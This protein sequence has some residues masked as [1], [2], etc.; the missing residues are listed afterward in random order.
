MSAENECVKLKV[1]KSLNKLSNNLLNNE[2]T[3]PMTDKTASTKVECHSPT[4]LSQTTTNKNEHDQEEDDK[5][6]L[7]GCCVCGDDT[8]YSN[9][10]LVYC[11]GVDCKVAVHQCC[12]GILNVPDDS[13]YCG[14]CKHK[15]ELASN[16]LKSK[17]WHGGRH[18]HDQ[19]KKLTCELC[20]CR[21]GALKRTQCNKWAH[22]V[23]ALYIPE[24]SFGNVK[25]MEPI[26]LKDIKCQRFD[27]KCSLCLNTDNSCSQGVYVNCGYKDGCQEW[28]HVTCAQRKGLLCEESNS[29]Y[30]NN[31]NYSIYCSEHLNLIL[32]QSTSC[33]KKL[34]PFNSSLCP[35]S[36]PLN[37]NNLAKSVSNL[38]HSVN[39][40]LISNTIVDDL[41]AFIEAREKEKLKEKLKLNAKKSSRGESHMNKSRPSLVKNSKQKQEPIIDLSEKKKKRFSFNN[42]S[43][44]PSQRSTSKQC[45]VNKAKLD[46]NGTDELDKTK[47][48]QSESKL[49]E[50]NF[51]EVKIFTGTNIAKLED[52]KF[53]VL[54]EQTDNE[55]NDECNSIKSFRS[56]STANSCTSKRKSMSSNVVENE[57]KKAKTPKP[58]NDD[59]N[60]LLAN[61][62]PTLT[63]NLEDAKLAC[64]SG[65]VT[66]ST[67]SCASST[68]SNFSKSPESVDIRPKCKNPLTNHTQTQCIDVFG[69]F[70]NKQMEPNCERDLCEPTNEPDNSLEE[71]LTKQWDLGAD[72]CRNLSKKFDC[73]DLLD[74]LY[75]CK[76]DNLEMEK[77]LKL[78][79]QNN[80]E[81]EQ[82][83][84]KLSRSFNQADEAASFRKLIQP[85]NQHQH[86]NQHEHEH[87]QTASTFSFNKVINDQVQNLVT[88][89]K[90]AFQASTNSLNYSNLIQQ[91]LSYL[92]SKS[93]HLST[94]TNNS[95]LLNLYNK[96]MQNQS[97]TQPNTLA[98]FQTTTWNAGTATC[99]LQPQTPTKSNPAPH[100]TAQNNVNSSC[101]NSLLSQNQLLQSFQQLNP[102]QQQQIASYYYMAT[103]P[104]PSQSIAPSTTTNYNT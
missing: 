13:W 73:M 9:N 20:P 1:N 69:N 24:I 32:S 84:R 25:T 30:K 17:C 50:A 71:M 49:N 70:L 41:S 63:I 72:L 34:P 77:K 6:M 85:L 92:H 18:L 61:N 28:F 98:H 31:L 27:K 60:D 10:L 42:S 95:S 5:Q 65:I 101:L 56:I 68:S 16:A 78:L 19:F 26:I 55:K 88:T 37:K 103:T 76:Q 80:L 2:T 99:D 8:G 3:N 67:S 43:S 62:N 66:P 35:V 47:I 11:D 29:S 54:A 91:S 90:S 4:P 46:S 82:M 14:S 94:T 74:L 75:K 48:L 87:E 33:L 93:P 22:V 81:N 64:H 38:I 97:A 79:E 96:Q 100:P 23:C 83:N 45:N 40:S 36:N 104:T 44:S 59:S 86:Q 7:G 58:D 15:I 53:E 52:T 51:N 57:P 89:N 21:D 12:Y 39:K 102:M